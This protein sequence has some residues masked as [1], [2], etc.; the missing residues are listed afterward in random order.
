MTVTTTCFSRSCARKS[1]SCGTGKEISTSWRTRSPISRTSTTRLQA[2]RT[3][4]TQNAA[5]NCLKAWESLILWS[6]NWTSS[7]NSTE[8]KRTIKSNSSSSSQLLVTSTI[9]RRWNGKNLQANWNKE[10]IEMMA[11]GEIWN[12]F[13]S[14]SVMPSK[15]AWAK[16]RKWASSESVVRLKMIQMRRPSTRSEV[17]NPKLSRLRIESSIRRT[18]WCNVKKTFSASKT[19]QPLP[20]MRYRVSSTIWSNSTMKYATS[21]N[22]IGGISRLKVN[23]R[24]L[25]NTRCVVRKNFKFKRLMRKWDCSLVTANLN[26]SNTTLTKPKNRTLDN[27]RRRIRCR[28]RLMRSTSTWTS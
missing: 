9:W 18:W 21:R 10:R 8:S 11:K 22:R 28:M 12:S 3:E 20:T 15:S 1:Q 6:K 7:D 14:K 27:S 26:H 16:V 4:A 5:R 24:K 19:P 23:F 17:C 13:R 25:T 2:K